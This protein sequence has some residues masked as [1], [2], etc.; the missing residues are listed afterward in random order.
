M[1][2][3]VTRTRRGSRRIVLAVAVLAL[4]A[5][6]G[7]TGSSGG[8][9]TL[10]LTLAVGHP[11]RGISY[12]EVLADYFVPELQKRVE[13][14]TDYTLDINAAFGG[15]IADHTEMIN[16]VQSGLADMSAPTYLFFPSELYLHN[17]T[18]YMP[19][20][21][22]DSG[23]VLR[24]TRATF[25]ENPEMYRLVEEQYNQRIIALWPCSNYQILSKFPISGPSDLDGKKVGGGGINLQ[26]V[27]PLGATPVNQVLPEI[28][29]NLQTGVY[30]AT[31]LPVDSMY[32]YKLHE[33]TKYLNVVDFGATACGAI[34]VNL[35]TW[36]QFPPDVQ[37]VVDDVSAEYEERVIEA[38]ERDAKEAVEGM[39]A[40]GVEVIEL[41][42]QDRVEWAESLPNLVDQAAKEADSRGLPGSKVMASYLAALEE[43]GYQPP[44]DWEISGQ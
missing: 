36:E 15:T 6:C 38:T 2:I 35:D 18:F 43:E 34:H 27:E 7:G 13:E 8:G 21:P 11:E 40:A 39:K 5:A 24:A 44:R 3:S 12:S 16:A 32:G 29:T 19:F 30:G 28:Y 9:Q 14:E 1:R 10:R 4:A 31:I 42:D 20:G 25:D 37:K 17:L 41:S 23:T 22:T 26:F 33:Q